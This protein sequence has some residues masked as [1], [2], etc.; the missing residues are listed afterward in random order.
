MLSLYYLRAVL[1]SLLADIFWLAGLADAGTLPS[2][3]SAFSRG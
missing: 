2:V 1:A 3:A